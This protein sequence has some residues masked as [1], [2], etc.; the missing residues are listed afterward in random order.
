MMG[1]E[2]PTDG[3]NTGKRKRNEETPDALTTDTKHPGLRRGALLS[4]ALQARAQ[5]TFDGTRKQVA[6]NFFPAMLLAKAK[7]VVRYVQEVDGD[8]L[9]RY[10]ASEALEELDALLPVVDLE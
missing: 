7:T 1:S 8:E 5:R 4:I 9:V 3:S 6:T 2:S 10:Q